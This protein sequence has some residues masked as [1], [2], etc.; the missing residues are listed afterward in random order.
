[1]LLFQLFSTDYAV[2][3]I[4]NVTFPLSDYTDHNWCHLFTPSLLTTCNLI[5]RFL[6][7][8]R[9]YYVKKID[10]KYIYD[11]ITFSLNSSWYVPYDIFGNY[12]ITMISLLELRRLKF[13]NIILFLIQ[14]GFFFF[15]IYS[16]KH[17]I[18]LKSNLQ[19]KAV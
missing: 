7:C 19:H 13:L 17:C 8:K 1:M 3:I 16:P 14:Y 11:K 15:S 18:F 5:S 12:W 6:L 10:K 9:N 2:V 4:D